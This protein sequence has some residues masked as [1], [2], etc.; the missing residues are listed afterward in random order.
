MWTWCFRFPSAGILIPCA[1]SIKSLRRALREQRSH[2]GKYLN[3]L[4]FCS[5]KTPNSD[6]PKY[7]GDSGNILNAVCETVFS[8]SFTALWVHCVLQHWESTAEHV[9]ITSH[10]KG[11]GFFLQLPQDSNIN[12]VFLGLS[13]GVKPAKFDF[14]YLH[15]L[16]KLTWQHLSFQERTWNKSHHCT[17]MKAL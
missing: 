13:W 8:K 9:L 15:Q 10:R 3:P 4:L 14:S 17:P 2:W 6:W 5:F 11:E 1:R 7:V 16:D 12:F